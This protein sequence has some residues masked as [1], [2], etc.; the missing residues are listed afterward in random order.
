MSWYAVCILTIS[1]GWSLKKSRVFPRID[2]INLFLIMSL[3]LWY[4]LWLAFIS[5]IFPRFL[6]KKHINCTLSALLAFPRIIHLAFV[7][8]N[9]HI[10]ISYL[11]L[12][13]RRLVRF[14]IA[15]DIQQL[16]TLI[17]DNDILILL[18]SW[19]LSSKV[20][21]KITCKWPLVCDLGG[22]CQHVSYLITVWVRFPKQ[23]HSCL[24][25]GSI[26]GN[27]KRHPSIGALLMPC[28]AFG[29]K[30]IVSIAY[31]KSM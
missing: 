27:H 15:H 1:V 22:T 20:I 18:I 6:A 23:K 13:L 12:P 16:H 21:S 7:Y 30:I 10:N 24:S 9:M 3:A 26:L 11:S 31:V 25:L 2:Y 17:T 4:L 28:S 29:C 5:V 14:L 19:K 8:I